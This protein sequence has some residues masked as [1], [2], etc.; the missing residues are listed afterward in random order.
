MQGLTLGGMTC[1]KN[2]RVKRSVKMTDAT[3]ADVCGLRV[4][5]DLKSCF[6]SAV[7]HSIASRGQVQGHHCIPNQ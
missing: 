2:C 7:L 6:S 3:S 4:L 1:E 5:I